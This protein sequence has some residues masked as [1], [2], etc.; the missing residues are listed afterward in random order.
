[1]G[2]SG[3]FVA[4][5][6]SP[7]DGAVGSGYFCTSRLVLTAKHVVSSALPKDGLPE[8]STRAKAE[9]FERVFPD[10][11]T[12]CRVRSLAAG[13]GGPFVDAIPVWWSESA[14]V[15]LLALTQ[16]TQPE[17]SRTITWANVPECEPIEVTAVGFPQADTENGVRESRQISGLLNPLSGVKAQRLVIQVGGSI[18]E[19]PAG[20]GSSWAGMSGAALFSE[21][22]LIGVVLVDA[23]VSHPDR[24]ELWALPASA[25]ANDPAFLNWIR[26]DGGE[27]SWEFSRESP[28]TAKAL[29]RKIVETNKASKFAGKVQDFFDEYLI[30]EGAPG[31]VLFGGREGELA[32]LDRWLADDR[33]ASRFVLAGAP[34]AAA[35]A[36]SWF[37]G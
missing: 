36:L 6:Y 19:L 31:T 11:R 35:R 33:S 1:M 26:W 21:E 28:S 8:V 16:S 22:F 14:D 5:I 27:R 24:L 32:N 2:L 4:E 30:T 17:A 34:G 13:R 3:K 9:E 20:A 15:A 23:D 25:F 10:N 37:S 7:T 29:L 18:G 12:I